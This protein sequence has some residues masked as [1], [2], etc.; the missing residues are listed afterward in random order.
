V[1]SILQV[2]LI[3]RK[4]VVRSVKN[5]NVIAHVIKSVTNAKNLN[6]IAPA[7]RVVV[8]KVLKVVKRRVVVKK[9]LKAVKKR[10]VKRRTVTVVKVKNATYVVKNQTT[11]P[12]VTDVTKSVLNVH[13]RLINAATPVKN[14]ISQNQ[15]VL[16]ASKNNYN[17]VNLLYYK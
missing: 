16:V 2:I 10:V 12:A 4:S 13:V 17:V 15:I 5:L 14:A 11:V 8:K 3:A 1:I 9:V 6:A 7:V